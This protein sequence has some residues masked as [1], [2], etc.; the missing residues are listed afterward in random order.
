MTDQ[1]LVSIITPIF[2]RAHYIGETICSVL[3]QTYPNFELLVVDNGST[4]NT[5][6]VVSSF[7]DPRIRYF[8]QE[9]SGSPVSPR[10]RGFDEARGEII[11]FLDSDDVWLPQKLALQIRHLQSNPSQALVYADCH[12]MNERG[13]INGLYSDFQKP[14]QG[15]ILTSLLRSNFI[16]ALTVAFKKPMI[17]EFGILNEAY[18]IPHDLDLYLKIANRYQ[19]GYI[20]HPLA[21]LRIHTNNL[22]RHRIRNRLEIMQVVKPWC[23][24]DRSVLQI[25]QN[26]KRKIWAFHCFKTGLEMLGT[27]ENYEEGKQLLLEAFRHE[28]MNPLYWIGSLLRLTPPPVMRWLMEIARKR[29]SIEGIN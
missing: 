26:L 16:P 28:R 13:K 27:T 11:C 18:L 9:N 15:Y 22:C 25:S 23:L 24:G 14:H 20:P 4:D 3:A 5:R 19:I 7:A 21:K 2:N 10:N 8:H 1:P 17:E 12:L 29:W 6:E